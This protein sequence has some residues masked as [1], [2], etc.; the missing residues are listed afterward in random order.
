M[1]NHY[2]P[3]CAECNHIGRLQKDDFGYTVVCTNPRCE[4]VPPLFDNPATDSPAAAWGL[5]N[6]MQKP[7]RRV[8]VFHG[9]TALDGARPVNPKDCTACGG[10]DTRCPYCGNGAN[11]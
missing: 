4:G 2:P 9:A 6:Y 5:W 10:G 7:A 8:P 3:R 11:P 1:S